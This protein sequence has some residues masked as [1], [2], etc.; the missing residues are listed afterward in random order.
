VIVI[1]LASVTLGLGE[2]NL[3]QW[4]R[5]DRE[6]LDAGEFWRVVTGHLVHL[7]WGHLWLN[8][9]A[10]IVMAILF[11][12]LM[13]A[14]DWILA[15]VLSALSIDV[16]LYV[17]EPDVLWYVGLSGALHG[18]MVVGA[19]ALRRNFPPLGYILLFGVFSKLTY[20]QLVGPIPFSEETSGGPV[21]VAAHFYG[22]IGGLLTQII[23]IL[24]KR[25]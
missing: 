23:L 13:S 8:V 16:G 24:R 7:S 20:E 1:V 21:L 9:I 17:F 2:E 25:S 19:F 15:S 12:E 22:T 18:L 11:D 14:S 10:L 5:F 4:G 6:G 3:R